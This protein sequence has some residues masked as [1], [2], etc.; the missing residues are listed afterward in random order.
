MI[1]RYAVSNE[2]LVQAELLRSSS[3]FVEGL[4]HQ[5]QL[6]SEMSHNTSQGLAAVGT[7]VNSVFAA[8]NTER[9]EAAAEKHEKA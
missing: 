7:H 6:I 5:A 3:I 1:T 4:S 8:W 2:S 9:N